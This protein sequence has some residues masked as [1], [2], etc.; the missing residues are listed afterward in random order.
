MLSGLLFAIVLCYIPPVLAHFFLRAKAWNQAIF[1]WFPIFLHSLALVWMGGWLQIWGSSAFGLSLLSA[2]LFI[3]F[4][5][6]RSNEKMNALGAVHLPLGILLLF[7]GALFPSSSTLVNSSWWVPLHIVFILIGFGC[8][9]LSFGQSLLFLLVRHRLKTKKLRGIL[10][11]PSLENLDRSNHI[12]ATLGFVSLSAGVCAGWF[13]AQDLDS[14]RWDFG[15]IGSVSLWI[16]YAASIHARLILGRRMLWSA[17]FSI[18]GF[19]VLSVILLASYVM[20]GWHMGG[21]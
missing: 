12:G 18:V 3:G 5:I 11:L 1:L 4:Q 9:A 10:S 8:F 15:T 21:A 7:M 20:G 14:W 17:W 19:G 16:W 13:W 6:L 2:M